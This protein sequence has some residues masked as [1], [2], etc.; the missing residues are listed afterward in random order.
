MVQYIDGSVIAQMGQPDMRTPIAYSLGWP[1]RVE[2][3]VANL[4]LFAV[5]HL[6]FEEPDNANFP[7]LHLAREAFSRGGTAPTVMNAANE[8]AVAAFLERKILFTDIPRFI[9][10][11]LSSVTIVEA[12]SLEKI[13]DA[14]LTTRQM[15]VGAIMDGAR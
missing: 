2:S 5:S 4:D 13:L 11:A 8:V 12:D 6:D 3:G 14:D 10:Q 7:C 15:L 9:E 1:E